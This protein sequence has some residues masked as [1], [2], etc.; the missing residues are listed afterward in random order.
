MS[1]RQLAC[2]RCGAPL[3]ARALRAVVVC[4]F[5][6]ASV[7]EDGGLVHTAGF[8]RALEDLS[9]DDGHRPR[10]EV[11]GVPYRVLGLVARG[12]SSDVF[13]AERAQPITERVLLK[14]LRDDADRDL[15]DHEWD[16]LTALRA[17]GV[18]G[19]ELLRR[20]PALVSRGRLVMEG[21]DDKRALIVRA[22]SGFVDTF[23]D[24]LR[25]HPGGVDGRH[26]VWMWRRTLEFLAGLHKAGWAHGAVLPQHLVVHAR[27]HGVLLVGWSCAAELAARAPLPVVSD[28]Q[29]DLYAPELLA[30][31]PRSAAAD[32]TMSAR[33]VARL[34]G[35]AADRV[36]ASVPRPVA[37]IVEEHAQGRGGADAWALRQRL[38]GAAREAYG[39]SRYHALAMPGWST[40]VVGE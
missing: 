16:A 39:P 5:C 38:G 4:A 25:A 17:G 3:P 11:A 8:R 31:G 26:A 34:L 37:A 28:A 35:G 18:A 27:D 6:G 32:I 1:L 30:G 2:P 10:V 19:A 33:C 7:A 9:R 15:M 20:L 24:V 13:L 12:E 29:R 40:P 36:P 23:E 22:R 21:R 14:V